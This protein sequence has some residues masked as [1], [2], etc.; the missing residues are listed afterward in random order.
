MICIIEL[1]VTLL[2][3][4]VVVYVLNMVIGMLALPPQV[5]TIA[6]L[7]LGLIVLFWLL[8][9]FGIYT[10]SLNHRPI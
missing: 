8:N 6:Y 7:I 5:K 1:L 9:Y 10:T 4:C 2:L 3:V